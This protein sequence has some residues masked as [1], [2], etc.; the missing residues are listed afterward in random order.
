GP[1]EL[2]GL[3]LGPAERITIGAPDAAADAPWIGWPGDAAP[4]GEGPEL[5]LSVADGGLAIAAVAA[6]LGRAR[7][8]AMLAAAAIA[9]GKVTLIAGAEPCRRTYWLVAPL[10]QWR[11]KKVR[12]LVAALSE[13]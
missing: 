5:L 9:E 8:P 13:A 7:V 6:G 1:G 2:E 4:A 11:Q 10:P 3:Q 12:A